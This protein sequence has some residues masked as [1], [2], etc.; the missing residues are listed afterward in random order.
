MQCSNVWKKPSDIHES[1]GPTKREVRKK[2]HHHRLKH[3]LSRDILVP[4]RVA[5]VAKNPHRYAVDS[6]TCHALFAVFSA[7][8]HRP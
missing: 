4:R 8:I 6:P 5:C 7:Q 1:M 3:A 2:N